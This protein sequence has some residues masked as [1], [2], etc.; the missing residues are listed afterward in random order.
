M[1]DITTSGWTVADRETIAASL[2][3]ALLAIAAASWLVN[4]QM[5]LAGIGAVAFVAPILWQLSVRSR[6]HDSNGENA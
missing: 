5:L 2:L 6:T 1:T 3:R 4:S